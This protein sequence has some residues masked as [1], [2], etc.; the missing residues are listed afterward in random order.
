MLSFD[1]VN[2]TVH[3]YAAS[4][5]RARSLPKESKYRSSVTEGREYS[6]ERAICQIADTSSPSLLPYIKAQQLNAQKVIIWI[7]ERGN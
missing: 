2:S 4:R 3:S 6:Y 7:V 5:L 1:D